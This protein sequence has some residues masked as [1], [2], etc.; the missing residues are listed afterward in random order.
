MDP[1]LPGVVAAEAKEEDLGV[2]PDL[3]GDTTEI[4]ALEVIPAPL[5]KEQSTGQIKF[6]LHGNVFVKQQR[7]QKFWSI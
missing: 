5:K 4:G 6:Q 7:T 2:K 1:Q 3:D